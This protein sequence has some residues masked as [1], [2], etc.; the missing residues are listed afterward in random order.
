[1]FDKT[2]QFISHCGLAGVTS[3]V[4]KFVFAQKILEFVGFLLTEDSV[5]PSKQITNFP[6]P[7]DITGVCSWFEFVNQ[8]NNA[9]ADSSLMQPF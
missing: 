8:I 9:Y 2:C 7:Q 1:M 4:D 3:N 6:E 5:K